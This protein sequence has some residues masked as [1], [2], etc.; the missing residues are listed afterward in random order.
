MTEGKILDKTKLKALKERIT[1][2]EEELERERASNASLER[3]ITAL[4]GKADIQAE[5]IKELREKLRGAICV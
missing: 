4:E 3:Y 2:L 5:L 1:A